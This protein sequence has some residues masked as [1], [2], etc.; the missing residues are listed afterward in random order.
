MPSGTK[1]PTLSEAVAATD[2]EERRK[3]Q[4]EVPSMPAPFPPQRLKDIT[5]EEEVGMHPPAMSTQIEKI[6]KK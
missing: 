4:K 2:K 1:K 5:W 3:T 6:G